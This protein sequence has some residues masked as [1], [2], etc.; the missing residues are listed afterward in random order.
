MF[1][2]SKT[3][4]NDGWAGSA[5][6]VCSGAGDDAAE[7]AGVGSAAAA[8]SAVRRTEAAKKREYMSD[9]YG[10]G[11]GDVEN[12]YQNQSQNVNRRGTRRFDRGPA[13]GGFVLT[14]PAGDAARG[15]GG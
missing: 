10:E 14:A 5:R 3:G 13:A 11:C 9:T 8:E 1:R 4:L 6:G 2:F 15:V 7:V 12:D